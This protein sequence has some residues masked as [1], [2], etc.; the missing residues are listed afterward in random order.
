M[1]TIGGVPIQWDENKPAGQ[2]SLGI[3]DDQIRSDKTAL[4]SGLAAEH[5]W[6]S[7][8]G[9][10]TGAH[11]LGSA[12]PFFGPQSLVSSTGSDGRLYAASDTSRLFG[13]GSGGTTLY[14]GA[15]VLS[16]G[17]FPG[18]TTP[19]RYY[20]AMEMGLAM[21]KS[22]QVQVVF[23]NSG[24][25][26]EP[27][28]QL[29]PITEGGFPATPGD[30]VW[31]GKPVVTGFTAWSTKTNGASTSTTSFYWQATGYRVL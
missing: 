7:T 27:F 9:A 3:G 19:Q 24:F 10:N 6:E 31:S 2:D 16:L 17:S 20:W 11:V 4:R 13:V 22:G 28:I 25:S 12:R 26:V 14:G 21:T 29:T 5:I 1:P 8:G 15:T 23:P 18:G 30:L